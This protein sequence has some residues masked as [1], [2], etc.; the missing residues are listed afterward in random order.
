MTLEQLHSNEA[1]RQEE[2]PVARSRVF[3]AHAGVCPLPHRVT[4]AVSQYAEQCTHGD[5]EAALPEHQ[6]QRTRE[7]AAA[8]LQAQPDEIA[9][10][11]PTS[12]GLS[13]VAAGL[14]L[15]KHDNVLVY[16][17]DYPS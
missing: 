13:Y 5:Q 10:V 8:L 4:Q 6:F 2:F 3:L 15:G 16:L 12:L 11:G 7:L 9:F 14:A 17:E 1:L